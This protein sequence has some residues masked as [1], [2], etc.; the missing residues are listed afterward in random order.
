M[1]SPH[2]PRQGPR[3]LPLHLLTAAATWNSSRFALPLLKNGL[4]PWNPAL[5]DRAAALARDLESAPLPELAGAVDAELADRAAALAAGIDAYRRHPYRRALAEPPVL[6]REGTTRLLDYGPPDG[7]PILV[8]PSLINRAEILDLLPGRSMLRALSRQGLRPLLVEWNAP[9]EDERSFDLSAYIAGRLEAALDAAIGAAGAPVAVMGYCM[10]GLLALALALRRRRDVSGLALLATP[11]DFHTEDALAQARFLGALIGPIETMFGARGQI[12]TDILQILFA[13]FDPALAIRKFTRFAGRDPRS[14][15]AIRFVAAED[16]LND[17]VPLAMPV[18]R[19]CL[20]GW[21]GENLPA[22]GLW[23][24]AGRP[25]LPE[26]FRGPAIIVVPATD[27]LVPPGSA[28]AL[29]ERM[30][31]AEVLTPALGHIGIVIGG[32]AP[33]AV[34]APVASWAAGLGR[35]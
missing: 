2:R 19:E 31:H 14:P 30:P 27:R 22:R 10:G 23:R 25:V 35:A 20:G 32:E 26:R 9:G 6:W 28:A 18:A 33:S 12:P 29:A 15:D 8:I 11:W 24:V 3:P 13:V 16:W 7:R 4:L 34:W 21:Y 17:G 1:T 5:I